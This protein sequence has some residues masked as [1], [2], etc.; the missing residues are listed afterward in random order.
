MHKSADGA[1]TEDKDQETD[2][3]WL[4]PI[5]PHCPLWVESGRSTYY[6]I[7][8]KYLALAQT[9]LD[10]MSYG[11]ARICLTLRARGSSSRSFRSP[12]CYSADLGQP[13]RLNRAILG[14]RAKLEA[15]RPARI[16]YTRKV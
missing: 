10:P 14:A 6:P 11:S 16:S 4:G 15:A 3:A 2:Q 1:A 7:G 13:R 9:Q 5:V 8:A 12:R